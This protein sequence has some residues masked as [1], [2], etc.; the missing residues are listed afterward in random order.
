MVGDVRLDE[1]GY[2]LLQSNA[3]I[4]WAPSGNKTVVVV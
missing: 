4:Y 3:G 2:Q 1:V